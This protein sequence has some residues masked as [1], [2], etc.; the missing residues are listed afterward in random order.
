MGIS[1]RAAEPTACSAP[2]LLEEQQ[3]PA[4][5]FLGRSRVV[6]CTSCCTE[7]HL[8]KGCW[9]VDNRGE[10]AGSL[11]LANVVCTLHTH[12]PAQLE[13]FCWFSKCLFLK[14][15]LVFAPVSHPM[16]HCVPVVLNEAAQAGP[17]CPGSGSCWSL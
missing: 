13:M 11:A 7:C 12:S 6:L 1:Q 9:G 16:S 2:E 4:G 17:S 3:F 10:G 8:N 15:R 5:C 14:I